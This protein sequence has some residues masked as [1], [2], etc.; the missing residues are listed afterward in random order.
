MIPITPISPLFCVLLLLS[1]ISA[2]V[3]LSWLALLGVRHGARKAFR[4]RLWFA[5]PLMILLALSSTFVLSFLY[6]AHLVDVDIKRDEAARNIVLGKPVVVAGIAMPVG[7][8]LHS[9]VPGV[10]EAFDS[11]NFPVPIL[12]Q[13]V[14]AVSV[15][16]HVY[17][18]ID[19]NTH[20]ATSMEVT[21][22]SDQRID[23][24][25]CEKGVAVAFKV[26]ADKIL[27]DSCTLGATNHLASL[28]V[29]AGAKLL[30]HAGPSGGWTIFLGPETRM[31]VRGLLLQ[32]ARIAVDRNRQFVGFS[33]AVLA[34][35][36]RLGAVTYP[37]GIRIRSKDWTSPGQ[38]S[39][40][41]I[42]TP[43]RGLAAKPDGQSDVPFGR[44]IVQTMAGQVLAIVPNQQVGVVDFEEISVDKRVN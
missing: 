22:A 13:G 23:G 7:T 43:V 25:L 34:T 14:T 5:M 12:V 9:M 21:L 27:F 32:G 20:A 3:I 11:A 35:D 8:R 19:S 38:D 33:E 26:E 1:A 10:P 36:L 44:S 17:L 16:R 42:L 18:D 4:A 28:E 40:S 31:I 29:P 41:L 39:D 2:L 15:R 30:A 24:W 37:A 6:R